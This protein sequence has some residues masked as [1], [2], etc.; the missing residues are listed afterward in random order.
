MYNNSVESCVTTVSRKCRRIV[1][2]KQQCRRIVCNNSVESCATV[3]FHLCNS[4]VVSDF[5]RL[6]LGGRRQWRTCRRIRREVF[7]SLRISRDV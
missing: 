5:I 4:V 1:C 3:S 6:H 7:L 2:N